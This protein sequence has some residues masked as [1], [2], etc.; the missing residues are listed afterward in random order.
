MK[1]SRFGPSTV[2]NLTKHNLLEQGLCLF[3]MYV[4]IIR[5]NVLKNFTLEVF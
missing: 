1:I 4:K 2:E 5:I 3:V